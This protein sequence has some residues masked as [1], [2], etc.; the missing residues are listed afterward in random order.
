MIDTDNHIFE[1]DIVLSSQF[2][3]PP[4]GPATPERTLM[5]AVLEEAVRSLFRYATTTDRK[6]RRIYEEARD[7]FRSPEQTRLYDFENVCNVVGIDAGYFRRRLFALR[8]RSRTAASKLACA[9][10]PGE[11]DDGRQDAG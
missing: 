8:E 9:P 5:V 1:P 3:A 4:A 2:F 10:R 6:E 11:N 7:W